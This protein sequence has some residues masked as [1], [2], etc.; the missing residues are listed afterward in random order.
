MTHEQALRIAFDYAGYY[1]KESPF[2]V[3]DMILDWV[4]KKEDGNTGTNS[5]KSGD[6]AINTEAED[7]PT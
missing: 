7:T 1:P 5:S 4:K 3:A 6:S 2:E